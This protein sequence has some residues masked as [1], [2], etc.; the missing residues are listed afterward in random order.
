M[1]W[2]LGLVEPFL[3][4]DAAAESEAWS[5]LIVPASAPASAVHDLLMLLE[6]S[7]GELV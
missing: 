6:A 4:V 3:C 7:D 2:G 1:S 5:A